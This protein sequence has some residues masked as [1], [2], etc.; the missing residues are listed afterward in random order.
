[1]WDLRNLKTRVHCFENHTDD[2]LHVE[3]SPC[4]GAVFGSSSKDRRVNLW[5]ISKIG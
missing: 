1:M 3:Y 5:D 4:N 2:V